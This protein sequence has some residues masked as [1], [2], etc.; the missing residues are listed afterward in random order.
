MTAIGEQRLVTKAIIAKR[1][2]MASM[3]MMLPCF[4]VEFSIS[5]IVSNIEFVCINIFWGCL[6]YS[7]AVDGLLGIFAFRLEYY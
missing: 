3:A 1:N 7:E 2:I 4:L 6:F 5:L